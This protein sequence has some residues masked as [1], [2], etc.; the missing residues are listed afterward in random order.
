MLDSISRGILHQ[1]GD[2]SLLVFVTA[3]I[4]KEWLFVFVVVVV[5]GSEIQWLWL[6]KVNLDVFSESLS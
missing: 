4:W 5:S 6:G 2:S 1:G 3:R